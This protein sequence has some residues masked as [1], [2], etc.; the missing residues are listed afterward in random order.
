MQKKKKMDIAKASVLG[1]LG[2]LLLYS[3]GINLQEIG[4]FK[5]VLGGAIVGVII[6]F[7][8]QLTARYKK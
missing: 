8:M 2:Y 6:A 3:A 5:S 1:A 7:L 4:F